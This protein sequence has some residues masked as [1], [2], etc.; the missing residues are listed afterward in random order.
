MFVG[1]GKKLHNNS[2]Q[3]NYFHYLSIDDVA[4]NYYLSFPATQKTKLRCSQ[5][6][7]D[8]KGKLWDTPI[9]GEEPTISR[10]SWPEYPQHELDSFVDGANVTTLD[11][12]RTEGS[13]DIDFEQSFRQIQVYCNFC[14]VFLVRVVDH[15]LPFGYQFVCTFKDVVKLILQINLT[16]VMECPNIPI[17]INA[18]RT[19]INL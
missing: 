14:T 8:I 4:C 12:C 7:E 13:F 19:V 15:R 16:H 6:I 3:G 18:C 5:I 11:C 17:G 1:V 10:Q 2:H 9:S